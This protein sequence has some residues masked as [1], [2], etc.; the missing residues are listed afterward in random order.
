MG[1][2]SEWCYLFFWGVDLCFAENIVSLR[3]DFLF[4]NRWTVFTSSH[5]GLSH[6]HLMMG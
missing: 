1:T 5:V 4:M 6:H 3:V 2:E